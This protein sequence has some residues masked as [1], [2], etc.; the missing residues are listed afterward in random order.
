MN[1]AEFIDALS[2]ELEQTCTNSVRTEEAFNLGVRLGRYLE[3]NDLGDVVLSCFASRHAIEK[4]CESERELLDDIHKFTRLILKSAIA[5]EIKTN[6][7]W[8]VGFDESGMVGLFDESVVLNHNIQLKTVEQPDRGG[9]IEAEF[10]LLGD[11]A[12]IF[13][14]N[15]FAPVLTTTFSCYEE[16]SVAF[17]SGSVLSSYQKVNIETPRVPSEEYL[18]RLSSL[19]EDLSKAYSFKL[20]AD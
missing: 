16:E 19:R 15:D 10:L 5:E 7:G 6:F 4:L 18:D 1:H 11:L 8:E 14:R 9:D 12:A 20:L 3:R 17:G 13:T 2:V